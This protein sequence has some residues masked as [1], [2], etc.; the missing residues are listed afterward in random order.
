MDSIRRTQIKTMC[1]QPFVPGSHPL[2]RH[3]DIPEEKSLREVTVFPVR[4]VFFSSGV[5]LS[6]RVLME[7]RGFI[8]LRG[9]LELRGFIELR[10]LY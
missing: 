8:E 10:G 1:R 6:T 3:G 4:M 7:F 9:F 5:L 2:G